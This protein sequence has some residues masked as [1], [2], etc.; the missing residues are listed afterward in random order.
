MPVPSSNAGNNNNPGTIL[1][2]GVYPEFVSEVDVFFTHTKQYTSHANAC[3]FAHFACLTDFQKVSMSHTKSK[4]VT[5]NAISCTQMQTIFVDSNMNSLPY[6]MKF[7]C[8]YEPTIWRMNAP[9]PVTVRGTLT[10][11]ASHP[12]V[13][14]TLPVYDSH[15]RLERERERALLGTSP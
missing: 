9:Q 4:Y 7:F 8:V 1:L 12:A 3:D 2:I 5:Q 11:A 10:G 13:A 15:T 14:R 6:S